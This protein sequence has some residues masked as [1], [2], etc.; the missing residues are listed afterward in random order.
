MS[1]LVLFEN[2]EF[3]RLRVTDNSGDPWFIAKDIAV[4][5][6]YM[7]TGKAVRTY[8][9][10]I[11]KFSPSDSSTVYNIIPESD[12]YRLVLKSELPSAE[13]FQ[14][15]VV[16]VVLPS[17][18]KTGEYSCEQLHTLNM[19]KIYTEISAAKKLA[20]DL[21]IEGEHSLSAANKVVN[22]L[23]GVDVFEL[24]EFT[25]KVKSEDTFI[26]VQEL[27]EKYLDGMSGIEVN[28]LLRRKGLQVRR[29]SSWWPTQHGAAYAGVYVSTSKSGKKYV[30]S[31]IWS[32]K[33]VDLLRNEAAA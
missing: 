5:L 11:T 20:N 16:E 33:V 2:E 30:S 23:L 15:W 6:G 28:N 10:H 31:R 7:D 9:K 26:S 24:M 27:G 29:G 3:G 19:E 17:I 13:K 8:C 4:A 21:G 25:P 22:K 18:R 1:E 32:P 12:V 14:D